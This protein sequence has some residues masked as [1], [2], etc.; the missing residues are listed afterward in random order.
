MKIRSSVAFL[1][2]VL[3]LGTWL[4]VPPP[5]QAVAQFSDQSTYAGTSGGSANAQTITVAN[6]STSLIGIPLRFLAGFTNTGPMTIN[7]SG[8]GSVAVLRPSSIGNVALSGQEILAGD[9][10]TVASNGSSF[11]IISS[12]DTT[13]IGQIMEYRGTATPRGGL[14]ED[15]SCVSRT[16][17]APLFSVIGTTY[18]PC[19]GST[20][21]GVPDSRGDMIAALDNQGAN[22]AA[23]RI[24]V[25]GSGCSAT[26]VGQCGAQNATL[27]LAQLPTGITT[28]GSNSI[29]VVSGVNVT[30]NA[31]LGLNPAPASATSVWFGGSSTT[32]TSTG[33]N[34]ITATS[35]NTGGSAHSTLNP[36][37]LARRAIKY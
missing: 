34:T 21:F 12:V 32:V 19:D 29:S 28:S 2:A 3:A 22:G 37:S 5:R 1:F 35:N 30:Q 18:N 17:Y 26:S 6:Y 36:I 7:V 27:A 24:T 14:V 25:G 10:V 15:G 8:T 20:T 9:F 4:L 11:I 33:T 13:P 23:N 16:T 31:S